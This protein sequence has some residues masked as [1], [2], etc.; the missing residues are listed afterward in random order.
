MEKL[1]TRRNTIVFVCVLVLWRLYLSAALQLHPDEAYYWLWS[2]YLDVGYFDH[3]PF[4]AYF[5]WLTTLLS[6]SELWVR[7][8]ATI[9]SVLVSGLIWQLAMQLYRSVKIAAG[10]VVLF[11]VYPQTMLGLVVITPDI[12]VLLFWSLSIYIFWQ[13]IRTQKT[14]LWLALGVTFGLALLSKY[15]AVLM[16]PCFLIYL[17]LTDDRRWL[18]TIYPYLSLG[19]GL[20]CFLPVVIWNSNHDWISFAFQLKNGLGAQ[21]Y[22]LEKVAEYV[23]GQLLVTGPVVWFVGIYAAAVG[24]YRRD[25]ETVLLLSTALPVILFFGLSSLKKAAGPNWPAFAY[26]AFCILVTQFCLAEYSRLRRTVWSVAVVSSLILSAVVTLHARF[27]LIPLE[28]YS[29]EM[30]AADATNWFYG[31][32]ELGAELKKYPGREFAITPSHQLSAE[33]IYYTDANIV[34]QTALITRPSQFNMWRSEKDSGRTD[35]LYVWTAADYIGPDGAYFASAS[36][37]NSLQIFRDGVPTRTYYIVSG[38]KDLT[39]PFHGS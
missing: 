16:A 29:K 38:Q 35:G 26:F 23:G 9:V 22:S 1:L 21:G 27:N 4:V 11:N 2:R 20:L 24:I 15:T 39:P 10:S 37:S 30:A 14:W 32:R 34:A 12:P 13:I 36:R 28:R 6:K 19:I 18:K 25:K 7:L 8:S 33:I 17:L 5:I 31:W 3:P